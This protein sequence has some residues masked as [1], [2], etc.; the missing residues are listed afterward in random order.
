MGTHWIHL[1][2][3]V[4]AHRFDSTLTVYRN[5]SQTKMLS[6]DAAYLRMPC[7]TIAAESLAQPTEAEWPALNRLFWIHFAVTKSI[8]ISTLPAQSMNSSM[9]AAAAV[10]LW[11]VRHRPTFSNTNISDGTNWIEW[12]RWVAVP[13]DRKGESMESPGIARLQESTME[14]Q[15]VKFS[16]RTQENTVK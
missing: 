13:D 1:P 10:Y 7:Q 11:Y 12:R 4:V 16:I 2:T 8:R 14:L 9:I 6:Y 5:A 3:C 15:L